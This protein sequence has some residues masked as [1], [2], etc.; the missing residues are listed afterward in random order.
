MSDRFCL[1][2][3]SKCQIDFPRQQQ[4]QLTLGTGGKERGFRVSSSTLNAHPGCLGVFILCFELL[5]VWHNEKKLSV[6]FWLYDTTTQQQ[7][8][9]NNKQ[10]PDRGRYKSFW[11]VLRFSAAK[12]PAAMARLLRSRRGL[13]HFDRKLGRWYLGFLQPFSFV[14]NSARPIHK[15]EGKIKTDKKLPRNAIHWLAVLQH[16][17]CT[18]RQK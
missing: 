17:I 14:N 16:I 6:M 13:S 10:K 4:R 7:L 1:W 9:I 18:R 12:E 11:F 3:Q 5:L 15:K 8:I 2:N